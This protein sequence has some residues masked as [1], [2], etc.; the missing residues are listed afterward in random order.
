MQEIW[1]SAIVLAVVA[2]AVVYLVVRA[3]RVFSRRKAA[4]GCGGGCHGCGSAAESKSSPRLVSIEPGASSKPR[5][6]DGW[7][8]LD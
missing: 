8:G 7:P 5:N 4:A 1:Q 6:S 2:L 3:L